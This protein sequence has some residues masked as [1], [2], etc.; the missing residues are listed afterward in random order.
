M[1][2]L[3]YWITKLMIKLLFELILIILHA[4]TK[5]FC[6]FKVRTTVV[7]SLPHCLGSLLSLRSSHCHLIPSAA[8][9]RPFFCRRL[10]RFSL[11]LRS[12]S[13]FLRGV[14]SRTGF[15]LLLSLNNIGNRFSL[16]SHLKKKTS[17]L[18]LMILRFPASLTIDLGTFTIQTEHPN[19][20]F[21]NILFHRF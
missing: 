4:V 13:F 2:T 18:E 15:T 1:Q 10:L 3:F 11:A 17:P 5:S 7:C 16:S 20:V 19:Q 21:L 6:Q 12:L 14:P 8:Q 9:A